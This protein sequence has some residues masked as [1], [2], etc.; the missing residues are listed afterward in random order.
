MVVSCERD[1]G[2]ASGPRGRRPQ[3][4]GVDRP[5]LR[6]HG[7]RHGC[8][9]SAGTA[10]G[11]GAVNIPASDATSAPT[12]TPVTAKEKEDKDKN[13]DKLP[14]MTSMSSFTSAG[15]DVLAAWAELGGGGEFLLRRGAGGGGW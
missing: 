6:Q 9:Q 4:D 11:R 2:N 8:L 15:E 1:L 14:R 5:R 10:R 12:V 13:R 3:C 7:A